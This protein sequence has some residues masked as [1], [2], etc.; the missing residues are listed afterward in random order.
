MGLLYGTFVGHWMIMCIVFHAAAHFGFFSSFRTKKLAEKHVATNV[1]TCFSANFFVPCL[2]VLSVTEHTCF[3]FACSKWIPLNQWI[4]I[5]ESQWLK[6]RW[7]FSSFFVRINCDNTHK[8]MQNNQWWAYTVASRQNSFGSLQTAIQLSAAK[9]LLVH[10]TPIK[11]DQSVNCVTALTL[12]K[13]RGVTPHKATAKGT[14]RTRERDSEAIACPCPRE[15]QAFP[16]IPHPRLPHE[17]KNVNRQSV[18][19]LRLGNL[20]CLCGCI[21][22]YIF[23]FLRMTPKHTRQAKG[24]V[25]FSQLW[26]LGVGTDSATVRDSKIP[27]FRTALF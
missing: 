15:P 17:W 25:S 24:L 3:V 14:R 13:H 20:L 12:W 23:T 7:D 8:R 11:C 26:F 21:W 1:A 9:R 19:G 5:G 4:I 27:Q 10:W 18:F 6:S 16:A 2:Y 22:R